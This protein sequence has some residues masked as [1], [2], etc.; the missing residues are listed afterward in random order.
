MPN[1][2][3][4]GMNA[5]ERVFGNGTGQSPGGIHLLKVADLKQ[6]KEGG[7]KTVMLSPCDPPSSA[8][9]GIQ[10]A[11]DNLMVKIDGWLATITSYI[12][13][14]SAIINSL[15][16]MES[17][18]ERI[19][20]EIAKYMKILMDKMMEYV[21]KMLNKELTIA[22]AA[23]PSTMR[24]MFGDIKEIITEL[25]LCLYN[26]LTDSMCAMIA[27]LL[28]GAF[29]L[30]DMQAQAQEAADN[31]EISDDERTAPQVPMCYA[32]DL[33][34]QIIGA[35]KEQIGE[36][37]QTILDNVS[38]FISDIQEEMAGVTDAF[39]DI[40]SPLGDIMGSITAAL[41]FEN[42]K[43]NILGCEL[44]P[45]CPVADYYTLEDGG[46]A[47]SDTQDSSANGVDKATAGADAGATA[48]SGDPYALPTSNQQTVNLNPGR[49]PGSTPAKDLTADQVHATDDLSQ[50][51]DPMP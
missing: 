11:L 50:Y 1:A 18:L 36:A 49:G 30:E 22:V 39:A 17:L 2:T 20:C 47:Q 3:H 31:D 46:S 26:K 10:T 33:V 4:D 23:L 13:A 41:S 42:L 7:W 14:A 19:A 21:L 5:R 6:N 12:D 45:N 8:M 44:A 51:P 25:I 38:T 9:S 40:T 24:H 16:D 29:P 43:L 37:N 35:H 48:G 34:G 15:K 27:D 32:E 28:K